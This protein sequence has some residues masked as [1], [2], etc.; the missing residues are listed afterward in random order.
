MQ[1]NIRQSILVAIAGGAL[2]MPAAADM[3]GDVEALFDWMEQTYPQY[4]SPAG[5]DTESWKGWTYRAYDGDAYLGVE[6]GGETVFYFPNGFK[7][8]IPVGDFD[9]LLA[10]AGEEDDGDDDDDDG[11][12]GNDGDSGG[13]CVTIDWPDAGFEVTYDMEAS[14]DEGGGLAGTMEMHY[15]SITETMSKT[16]TESDLSGP[17]VNMTITRKETH[18]YSVEDGYLM[19]SKMETVSRVVGRSVNQTTIYDE[20]YN[21]GP[22]YE[23]CAG[24]TWSVDSVPASTDTGN[25]APIN[26]DTTAYE[27]EVVSVNESVTTSAGTFQAIHLEIDRADGTSSEEWI[28]IEHGIMIQQKGYEGDVL[29]DLTQASAIN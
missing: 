13:S 16:I 26:F 29:I 5:A 20:P 10:Q 17:G 21:T 19:R 15:E 28:S 25:G 6:P 23:Y 27:G 24:Q 9:D 4:L 11:D 3:H 7:R 1:S 12:D 14:L 8:R 22:A 2:A 18:Y